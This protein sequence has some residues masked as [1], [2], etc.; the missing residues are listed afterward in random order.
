MDLF[1]KRVVAYILDFFVVSAFM[2]IISYFAYFF[3]NYFNMFQIYHYFV[4]IL[5]ILI[6]TYFTILEKNLG[7][8]VGKRLM[9][10]E[11]KTTIPKRERTGRD[12]SITYSQ[13]LIRSLS[14]IYWFPII[15]DVILGKFTGKTRLLDGITRTTVIEEDRDVFFENK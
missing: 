10:I 5:P 14:K 13:G 1:L 2:W 8:T 7:A 4:F 15:F 6:L 9:F 11:V 12:Y 3:I